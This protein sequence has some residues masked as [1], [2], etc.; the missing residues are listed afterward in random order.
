MRVV[1]AAGAGDGKLDR[2][3]VI[4]AFLEG[5][6]ARVTGQNMALRSR[7][8]RYET[9]GKQLWLWGSEIAY[10]R[11]DKLQLCDASYQSQLTKDVLNDVLRAA[12]VPCGIFQDRRKWWVSCRPGAGRKKVPWPPNGCI[13]VKPR[14]L[15]E[16]ENARA[17]AK[18]RQHD[19]EVARRLARKAQAKARKE[20]RE[21]ERRE[22]AQKTLFGR[23]R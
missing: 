2:S 19:Q 10:W 6:A 16:I 23:S 7:G 14:N 21:Q 15:V 3:G 11:G 17:M 22:K 8:T 13:T 20:A 5:R 4:K 1:A 18:Q 12:A 9:D